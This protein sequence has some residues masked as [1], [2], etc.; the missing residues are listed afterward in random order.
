MKKTTSISLVFLSFFFLFSLGI[1]AEEYKYTIAG[2]NKGRFAVDDDFYVYLNGKPIFQDANQAYSVI[3]PIT[4]TASPGDKLRIVAYDIYRIAQGLSELHLFIDDKDIMKL[5]DNKWKSIAKNDKWYDPEYKDPNVH[6]KQKFFDQTFILPTPGPENIASIGGLVSDAV[7]GTPVEDVTVT[8]EFPN[9]APITTKTNADGRYIID[10]VE[11]NIKGKISFS[12]DDYATDTKEITLHPLTS[13]QFDA[14]LIPK[15]IEVIDEFGPDK[16]IKIYDE[17]SSD[18]TIPPPIYINVGK[19]SYGVDYKKETCSH[20]AA[21]NCVTIT[22]FPGSDKD[23]SNEI[24]FKTLD[25]NKKK[26][27]LT[28]HVKYLIDLNLGYDDQGNSLT[29]VD[30]VKKTKDLNSLYLE[31][32]KGDAESAKKKAAAKSTLQLMNDLDNLFTAGSLLFA[33]GPG[34]AAIAVKELA[35]GIVGDALLKFISDIFLGEDPD[36]VADYLNNAK[37]HFDRAKA[38]FAAFELRLESFKKSLS[39]EDARYI[40]NNAITALDELVKGLN[41]MEVPV[42]FENKEGFWRWG[43]KE[44]K[45]SLTSTNEIEIEVPKGTMAIKASADKPRPIYDST[46]DYEE[47]FSSTYPEYATCSGEFLSEVVKWSCPSHPQAQDN[48]DRQDHYASLVFSNALVKLCA[49]NIK[50]PDCAAKRIQFYTSA[51]PSLYI[52]Y[53]MEKSE[54]IKNA[55]KPFIYLKDYITNLGKENKIELINQ[56]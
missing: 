48:T 4:F 24:D 22:A 44:N 12:A 27:L 1:D 37:Y 14:T 56:E 52:N 47:G 2:V 36:K 45:L 31:T 16:E 33:W 41:C 23:K 35:K 46:R 50:V 32:V 25:E 18:T 13:N 8:I 54:R 53:L 30:M 5:S 34:T 17:F 10:G 51:S 42:T 20:D 21:K 7:T 43:S 38:Y 40:K 6:G 9:K 49:V 39:Y 28:A 15:K 11:A 55:E 19:Q 29:F 3:N 26:I